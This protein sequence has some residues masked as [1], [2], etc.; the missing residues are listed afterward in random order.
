MGVP[1]RNARI[2]D[3]CWLLFWGVA[4]CCWC[5][6]ASSRLGLTFDE[7]IYLARGLEHWRTGSHEGLLKL[8]TMPLP[9]DVQTLPIYLWER[10]RGQRFDALRDVE[11]ILPW[12][13]AGTLVFWWVLLVYGYLAGKEIAGAWGGR[14]AVALFS[15]E[16]N[17]LAHASLM[18]TDVAVSACLLAL[19][20]HFRR[21]RD[22]GW[23]LR[24][25]VP[26]V[27]FAAA[28]LAKAS[29]LVF[30]PLCMIVMVVLDRVARPEQREGREEVSP[31]P[32]LRPG[33]ATPVHDVAVIIAIGLAL[34]F[35]YCGC[36]W[37]EERSFVEW[38]QKL[39]EGAF[40]TG[41]V[42]FAEHLR[43]FSNAGEGLV[44]QIKHNMKGHSTYL[45]GEW[46]QR[47]FWYYFPVALSIKLVVPMLLLPLLLALLRPRALANW[48]CAISAALLLFSLT[49]RVQIGIRLVLPLVTFIV[50]GLSA[51]IA[52]G[53]LARSLRPLWLS[54]A[55]GTL[56][57]MTWSCAHVW[58]HALCYTNELWGGTPRGYLHLGDSNYDWGQGLPELIRWQRD[59][60][61]ASL[62]VWY[63]GTDPAIRSAGLHEV[64]LHALPIR[65]PSDVLRWVDGHYLAVGTTCL[66]GSLLGENIQPHQHA[67][68]FLRRQKPIARTAT[69][70]IYDFTDSGT[71]AAVGHQR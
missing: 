61:V 46:R 64:P 10:W 17:L 26:A 48:A 3:V 47:A 41:M 69:F 37:H 9:N 52:N 43:I 58:P 63:F 44:R 49:C 70:F 40:R 30:G 68:D 65:Q 31:R 71:T 35:V 51:A 5:V 4:S 42:W 11:T 16:P 54:V 24:V 12:A 29:G 59:H 1:S 55:A 39:P 66:Y 23:L 67:I 45:L 25:G 13:R 38:A 33:R 19:V 21:G 32:S 53:C 6:T 2:F 62:D 27:W 8:G 36:D 20:Y 60:G 57:W 56:I 14:L 15:C 50:V 22:C 18:T 7:P 34:V 28:V